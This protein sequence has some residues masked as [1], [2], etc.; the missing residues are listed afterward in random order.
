M[1]QILKVRTEHT[2]PFKTIFEVFKDVL[3]D[4][5]IVFQRDSKTEE[6][7]N[8]KKG[9]KKD[10]T[11][12]PKNNDD[13][14]NRGFKIVALD[15][16]MT[17]L[18]SLKLFE[19]EFAEYMCIPTELPLGINLSHF[20]KLI[21]SLDKD[22]SLTLT[23]D[24]SCLQYLNIIIDNPSRSCKTTYKLK[25]LD[26]NNSNYT[27]PSQSYDA[28]ITIPSGDFHRICS[29]MSGISDFVEITCTSKNVYLKCY[30]DV[31][32]RETVYT[33]DEKGI[34]IVNGLNELGELRSPIVQGVYE[35]KNITLFKKCSSLCTDI[36]I[37]MV[38]DYPIVIKYQIATLGRILLCIS[39][40]TDKEIKADIYNNYT[41][42][43]QPATS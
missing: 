26:L 28:L 42:N 27:L 35:L 13:S 34:S 41:D 19:S 17:I 37:Y 38:N 12:D 15:S 3:G 29:D 22:E 18:V 23:V 10:K 1:V 8:K 31:A 7:E 6:A 14:K 21:K 4:V 30:G 33:A 32:E 9:K 25:L 43:T 39:P 20:N 16:T 5:T 36:Q 2:I 11:D 24:D 40:V